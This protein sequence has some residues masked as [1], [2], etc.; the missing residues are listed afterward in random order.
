MGRG[1]DSGPL[2]SAAVAREQ[3]VRCG[4]MAAG[5]DGASPRPTSVEL[6]E[7]LVMPVVEALADNHVRGSEAFH[8]IAASRPRC[9][10]VEDAKLIVRIFLQNGL[11]QHALEEQ[12]RICLNDEEFP[13][14]ELDAAKPDTKTMRRIL[15]TMVFEWFF[16]ANHDADLL[17]KFVS[18]PLMEYE[19]DALIHYVVAETGK[20][21]NACIWMT[22]LVHYF[23]SRSRPEAAGC[24]HYAHQTILQGLDGGVGFGLLGREDM[25]GREILVSE[26]LKTLPEHAHDATMR[27]VENAKR[28]GWRYFQQILM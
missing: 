3:C 10:H 1:H 7:S 17:V 27:V 26:S 15:L 4:S 8:Y 2:V 12:R 5:L 19:E 16:N 20:D 6:N 9:R 22:L 25:Q 21:Q 28:E 24:V 11:W 13:A 18:L 23:L 14:W